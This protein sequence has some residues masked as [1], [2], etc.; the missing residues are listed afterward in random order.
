LRKIICLPF[1]VEGI[2][3]FLLR[4]KSGEPGE[5][6]EDWE[7]VREFTSEDASGKSEKYLLRLKTA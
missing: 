4:A 3:C 5:E 6:R 2:I 7:K 1:S